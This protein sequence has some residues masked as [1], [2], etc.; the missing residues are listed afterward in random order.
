MPDPLKT[1]PSHDST[2]PHR[3]GS[4]SLSLCLTVFVFACAT[5]LAVAPVHAQADKE[6]V[7][8]SIFSWPG[9]GFWFLAKEKN[10]APDLDLD[11]RIIE[12]PYESFALMKAGRLDATSSTIEYG[13]L[14]AESGHPAGIVTFA[15]LSYGTDRIIVRPEVDQP[16]DLK[17]EQVAVLEG[18]LSQIYMG[19]W[20]EQNGMKF[21]AVKYVN[22]I[23]DDA[24]AA[25]IGGNVA[26]GEFWEPFG[27]QVLKIVGDA[28]VVAQ[29]KEPFW[30][31]TALLA[32][33]CYF[34]EDFIAERPEV[35]AKTLKALYD[36][37]DYWSKNTEEA[38]RIIAE[39]LQF[40]VADVEAVIG[41]NGRFKEGGLYVYDLDQAARFMGVMDGEPPHGQSNG[42]IVDHF[43]L[44]NEWWKKFGLVEKTHDPSAGIDT[45][46]IRKVVEMSE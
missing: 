45:S 17:G 34:H 10:L 4:L 21:D 19:I 25:M 15:N 41:T 3:G 1:R 2:D 40:P 42:Q 13:P 32:D 16:A 38:N 44:T 11:I 8:I 37:I 24:A 7:R 27:S 20:L 6:K 28:R 36:A 31:K 30:L 26:A 5:L 12:D 29:S 18:G 22:L 43:K 9:Y 14:A 33:T 35:A 46:V 23:M 39:N